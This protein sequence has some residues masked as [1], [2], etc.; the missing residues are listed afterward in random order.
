M[1]QVWPGSLVLA[2]AGKMGGALLRGWRAKGLSPDGIAVI[3]PHL[4]PAIASFCQ[5]SGIGFA[6]PA[7][8][9]AVLVLAIKPQTFAADPGG[10]AALAD[11]RTLVVSILAGT[12]LATLRAGLPDAGAIVRAMPNLPA[13]VGYGA[14][15]LAAEDGL[16]P[17]R[18]ALAQTL[19]EAVGHVEWLDEALIDAVTA[20]SGSGP[21]YVFLLVEC[22]A[23]AGAKAGLP[24][25]VALRLARAT[26]EGAGA[27]MAREPDRTPTA[28]RE[29]VTSPGGTTAAALDVLRGADGLAPLM[30]RAVAA[31]KRRAGDLAG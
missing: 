19:L 21:A 25:D 22:L 23:D 15:G 11:A 29:A 30:A 27:L 12:T 6:A 17:A 13:A 20:V 3:D 5:E 24:A 10:F 31:A 7:Q 4:D 26:V 9:P 28:L 18:R 2:G 16:S 14:T 8:P 1:K